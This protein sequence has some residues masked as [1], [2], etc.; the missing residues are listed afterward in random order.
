MVPSGCV[1]QFREDEKV[2]ACDYFLGE[3]NQG[4]QLRGI[5]YNALEIIALLF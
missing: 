5:L 3:C 2:S 1:C 4:H